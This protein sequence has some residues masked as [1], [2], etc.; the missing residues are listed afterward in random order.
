M[1][2]ETA[3]GL[4]L[5]GVL[6]LA[7]GAVFG[8]RWA[9][10]S[11]SLLPVWLLTGLTFPVAASPPEAWALALAHARTQPKYVEGEKRYPRY[12]DLTHLPDQDAR[13]LYWRV[14][15]FQLNSLS[16]EPDIVLPVRLAEGKLLYFDL[17]HYGIDP[18]VYSRLADVDPYFHVQLETDDGYGKKVRKAAYAPW[19]PGDQVNEM[20]KYVYS[21]VAVLR[22]DWF[23]F[24]TAVAKDRRAGYY[25]MLGLGNTE[26]DFQKLIGANVAESRRLKRE[27]VA[28]VGKSGVT[29]QNRGVTRLQS[30]TGGYWFT[31]DYNASTD[32][33]NV[34]RLLNGEAVDADASEQYGVLPNG[35]FAYGLFDGKGNRQDTAPDFIA[36]DGKSTSN[37]HRVHAMLSCVRCHVEGL[38]PIDDFARGLFVDKIAVVT[39]DYEKQKELRQKQFSDL[40]GQLAR[41]VYDY[42][43]V[44]HVVN[45]LSPADNARAYARCWEVY[46]DDD[47]TPAKAAAELGVEEAAL[48]TKMREWAKRNNNTLDIVLASFLREPAVPVRREHFEESYYLLQQ[49]IGGAP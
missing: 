12:L 39:P 49:M 3:F 32:K 11:K 45:G 33:R 4:A 10:G 48:L 5:F 27:I 1:T 42:E 41:D 38:R 23:L 17:Y 2:P 47:M 19:I 46:A 13:D 28:N 26:A 7:A 9:R 34:L 20:M 44:L 6:C 30:L 14:L 40:K 36:A 29:L 16:R 24:Q 31:Q 21:R 37:D 43:R 15:S 25:D 8:H 22:G 35:L 18:T